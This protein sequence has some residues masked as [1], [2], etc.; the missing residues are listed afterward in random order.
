MEA[1]RIVSAVLGM[2]LAMN[3][4]AQ[5]SGET[6]APTIREDDRPAPVDWG[7]GPGVRPK[8][9]ALRAVQEMT[10]PAA[11][12]GA[13][14]TRGSRVSSRHRSRGRSSRCTPCCCRTGG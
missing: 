5:S 10:A 6:A 1:L 9:T 13:G 4:R 2:V 3:A 8:D 12:P 11:A 7:F 14:R